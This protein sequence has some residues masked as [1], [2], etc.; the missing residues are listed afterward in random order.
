MYNLIR[1]VASSGK[2]FEAILPEARSETN[3]SSPAAKDL[4]N[5]SSSWLR[6]SCNFAATPFGS[7]RKCGYHCPGEQ[8]PPPSASSLWVSPCPTMIGSPCPA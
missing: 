6:A 7:N 3:P 8:R 1:C 5:T 2:G 4:P